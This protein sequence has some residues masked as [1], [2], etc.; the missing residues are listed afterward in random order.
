MKNRSSRSYSASKLILIFICCMLIVTQSAQ[1]VKSGLDV[2]PKDAIA[3]VRVSDIP[4]IFDTVLESP[5]WQELKE[6]EQVQEALAQFQG[7][8]PITQLLA[9]VEAR[10]L[11]EIFFSEAIFAFMGLVDDK[12]EMA[13][14]FDVQKSPETAEDGLTQFLILMSGGRNYKAIP[15]A[16]KY[17]GVSYHG[18]TYEDGNAVK[19]G[20]LDNLLVLGINGGFEKV[21]DTDNGLNPPIAENP[22]FQQ[23]TQKVQL[24]GNAYAYADLEQGIPIMQALEEG[25]SQNTEENE[26]GNQEQGNPP[27]PPL[28]KGEKVSEDKEMELALMRS[29]KAAAVKIDLTGT[30]HEAYVHIEPEGPV[31]FF[32][33]GKTKSSVASCILLA[34]HPPLSSIK[35]MRAAD[36]VFVGLQLGDLPKLL[37][38]VTALMSESGQNPKEQ[39]EQ[40]KKAIGIDLKEDVLKA[41]TGEL[42]IALMTPKEKLNISK[43]KLDIARAVK[44]ILFIGI[45]DKSKFGELRQKLSN[46]INVEPVDEYQYK[47][48]T[49]HRSIVSAESLAPGVA[50]IPRYTYLDDLLVASNGSKYIEEVIDKLNDNEE[51][52][53][54]EGNLAHSWIL[55]RA[56]IGNIGQFAVEQ[57][58][59]G[60]EIRNVSL[61]DKS[62]A[63]LM[64]QLGSVE[65]SYAPEPEGIKLSI[66]SGADETWLTKALRAAT[67]IILAE[68]QK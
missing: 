41:L 36:G 63:E 44:P 47:G 33:D 50:L 58:L 23:M 11:I 62:A 45:K 15:E 60:N 48:A 6:N 14:I 67:I 49:I 37:E 4:K 46:L 55:V 52:T 57:N 16:Q 24:A 40:L 5:E 12:L 19:Y 35:L 66:I 61:G 27:Y 10:E 20:F 3:C 43:N 7:A 18:F 54:S 8:L 25:N 21:V 38:Q 17:G 22:Q 29:L 53:E 28:I 1:A 64:G 51:L 32:S 13:F 30:S 31:T 26:F 65:V 42:G 59:L 2:V 68:Q 34:S 56:E 39:L 9:G